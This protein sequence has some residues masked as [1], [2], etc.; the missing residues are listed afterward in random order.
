MCFKGTQDKTK[1]VINHK[2]NTEC[3]LIL[4]DIEKIKM[5]IIL[6]WNGLEA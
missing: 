2:C 6:T 5:G 3:E 1:K 4:S